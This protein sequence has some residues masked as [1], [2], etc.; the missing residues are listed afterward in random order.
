MR[1]NLKKLIFYNNTV[2]F[3]IIES[4]YNYVQFVRH[5]P[6]QWLDT[7]VTLRALK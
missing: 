6:C 5:W 7:P 4:A 3:A 1:L 2:R